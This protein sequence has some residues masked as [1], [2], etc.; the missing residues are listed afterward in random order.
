VN[1]TLFQI[2]DMGIRGFH[3]FGKVGNHNLP[4]G[5]AQ[6]QVNR[7]EMEE[8]CNKQLIIPAAFISQLG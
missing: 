6:K 7:T 2:V 5:F 4:I 1:E 8:K 3:S